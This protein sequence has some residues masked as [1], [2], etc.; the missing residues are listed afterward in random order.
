MLQYLK[1][2]WGK[3]WRDCNIQHRSF[4]FHYVLVFEAWW[5]YRQ[6]ILTIHID[7]AALTL[8]ASRLWRN[9]LLI[10]NLLEKIVCRRV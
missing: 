9:Y 2:T 6:V 10:A 4:D 3:L 8:V 7:D 5:S 1:V